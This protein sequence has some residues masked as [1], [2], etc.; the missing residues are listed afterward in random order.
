[1]STGTFPQEFCKN[2]F[3]LNLT[4]VCLCYFS[5]VG[6]DTN[7]V[8]VS[9]PGPWIVCWWYRCHKDLAEEKSPEENLVDEFEIKLEYSAPGDE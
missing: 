1:M 9:L 6:C 5:N 8:G 4:I 3:A 2:K 7:C